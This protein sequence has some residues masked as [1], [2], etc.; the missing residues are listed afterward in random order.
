MGATSGD[1]LLRTT[2]TG[3]RGYYRLEE[4]PPGEVFL[5]FPNRDD[6]S[7]SR[8]FPSY[9]GKSR[10][11]EEGHPRCMVRAGGTTRLDLDR[12]TSAACV[13]EGRIEFVGAALCPAVVGLSSPGSIANRGSGGYVRTCI[14]SD[15]R[16]RLRARRP[17]EYDLVILLPK[18]VYLWRRVTLGPGINAH[19]LQIPVGRVHVE[20]E[21]KYHNAVLRTQTSSGFEMR[22]RLLVYGRIELP[23]FP[24]GPARVLVE[25]YPHGGSGMV[26]KFVQGINVPVGGEVF[27]EV[28]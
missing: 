15:G 14:D 20:T 23:L 8:L 7:Y 4:L 27:V 17:G 13:F 16:F 5:L 6:V 1:G 10:L 22:C 19:S 11:L 12:S 9:V 21:G 3:E 24:A 18:D 2:R 25:T 28:P 26:E